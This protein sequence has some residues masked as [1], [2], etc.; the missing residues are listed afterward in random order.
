MSG[1]IR[2]GKNIIAA[3][4]TVIVIGVAIA[5]LVI[6][7]P[8]GPGMEKPPEEEAKE[9]EAALMIEGAGFVGGVGSKLIRITVRN[10][11]TVSLRITKIT[12]VGEGVEGSGIAVA[13]LRPGEAADLDV[14]LT[15][16]GG[17]KGENKLTFTIHT[18]QGD[19]TQEFTVIIE[20]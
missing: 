1:R 11:G 8:P 7:A 15:K 12:V 13:T 16:G 19:F 4:V 5:V 18:D 9:G 2:L 10:T 3:I 17:K 6:T 14:S 20:E